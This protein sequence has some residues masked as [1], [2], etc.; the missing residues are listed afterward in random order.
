ME[1]I[2]QPI[3]KVRFFP[4]RQLLWTKE[5]LSPLLLSEES[6]CKGCIS[7]IFFSHPQQSSGLLPSVLYRSSVPPSL[8][9]Q[10]GTRYRMKA[11]LRPSNSSSWHSKTSAITHVLLLWHLSSTHMIHSNDRF[12]TL[13]RKDATRKNMPVPRT[14]FSLVSITSPR[15]ARLTSVGPLCNWQ[16]SP[17]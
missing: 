9:S 2:I 11:I 10:G 1:L 16:I 7:F 5:K 6:C 8:F 15:F 4:T 13:S 3:P 12:P 14:A 17:P